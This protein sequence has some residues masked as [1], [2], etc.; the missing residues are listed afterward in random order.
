VEKSAGYSP[1]AVMAGFVQIE[2]RLPFKIGQLVSNSGLTGY[3]LKG[4][5]LK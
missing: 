2:R 5:L 1:K 3:F 4:I